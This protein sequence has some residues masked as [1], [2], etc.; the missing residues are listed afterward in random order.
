MFVNIIEFARIKKG[1]DAEFRKWFRWSHAVYAKFDGFISRRLLKPV[2]GKGNYA[3]IV[4]HRSKGTFM[5]MHLSP[6]RQE[7]WSRVEPLFQGTPMPYFYRVAI[8]YRGR[9]GTKS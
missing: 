1:K 6:A 4:E 5:K 3:A 8:D 2:D 7:A 9:K